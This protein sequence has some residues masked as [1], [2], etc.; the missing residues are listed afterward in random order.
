MPASSGSANAWEAAR[1][2]HYF[3]CCNL[4][5]V[6]FV[7]LVSLNDWTAARFI[8]NSVV[9]FLILA[10][11]GMLAGEAASPTLGVI[12]TAIGEYSTSFVTFFLW[13]M[14][15][16]HKSGR[17]P[18]RSILLLATAILGMILFNLLIPAHSSSWQLKAALFLAYGFAIALVASLGKVL[19]SQQYKHSIYWHMGLFFWLYNFA[20]AWVGEQP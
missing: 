5:W 13:N 20:F 2:A 15:F 11:I 17:I 9:Q 7:L 1:V 18:M 3:A 4:L 10:S 12:V 8:P 16:M 19:R 6:G 14:Q